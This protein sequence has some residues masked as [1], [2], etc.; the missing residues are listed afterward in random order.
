VGSDAPIPTVRTNTSTDQRSGLNESD[1]L[2]VPSNQ[3][4][5]HIRSQTQPVS[6]VNLPEPTRTNP[7]TS[8]NNNNRSM[9]EIPAGATTSDLPAGVLYNVINYN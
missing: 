4:N 8:T 7:A 2:S 9:N 1:S 5:G 3:S 6:E